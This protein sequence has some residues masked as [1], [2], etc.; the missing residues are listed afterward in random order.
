MNI[1]LTT[2]EVAFLLQ[3]ISQMNVPVNKVDAPQILA[4]A[5]AILVKLSAQTPAMDNILELP[6]QE[7]A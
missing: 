3:N 5:Q 1:E 7:A 6:A 2:E 4:I